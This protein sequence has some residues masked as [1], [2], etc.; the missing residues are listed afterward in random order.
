MKDSKRYGKISE[1]NPA[2]RGIKP[3]I[4][5]AQ[6]N[7][8][9]EWADAMEAAED[10]PESSWGAAIAQFKELYRVEGGAWVK[11][12]GGK[13]ARGE[14]QG[15]DGPRQGDGGAETCI[16]PKCKHEIKHKR[17]TPCSEVECPECGAAMAGKE[18]ETDDKA[19]N[20]ADYLE[21]TIHREF[22][23]TA[24]DLFGRG[25]INRDERIAI[26][27]L[28]GDALDVFRHGLEGQLSELQTRDT[29]GGSAIELEEPKPLKVEI[30]DSS[31]DEDEDEKAGRRVRSDKVSILKSLQEKLVTFIDEFKTVIGW[32]EYEDA[33]DTLPELKGACGFKTFERNGQTWLLT[34]TTNAFRDRED[35][36]FTTKS[37]EDYVSRHTGDDEKGRFQFWHIPGTDFGTIHW[38]GVIGRFLYEAGTFDDTLTGQAF[39][40]FLTGHINGHP[41]FAPDGWGVSHEYKFFREDRKDGIYEWFDKEKTTVLPIGAASNPYT[42]ME[43]SEMLSKQQKEALEGIVGAE[44]AA[45]MIQEGKAD[46]EK[47]EKETDFKSS[48][49]AEVPESEAEGT[50]KETDENVKSIVDAVIAELNAEALDA[51]FKALGE[52]IQALDIGITALTERVEVIEKAPAVEQKE[53]AEPRWSWTA[54]RPSQSEHNT[55]VTGLKTTGGRTIPNAIANIAEQVVS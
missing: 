37:I 43:V 45:D 39:K 2:L 31:D 8:I 18:T 46:T 32:A 49:E 6:A 38:Q 21:S 55:D 28:I 15:T 1:A 16:C 11:R 27:S 42:K 5:L 20:V 54:Q 14:G 33:E 3:L 53:I 36:I 7:L 23:V 51:G 19:Q 52:A 35:E 41:E 10:G 4:T 22:T 48:D 40:G 9:A 47:L 30:V 50:E 17:G 26:S 44:S 29:W 24:D 12:E 25:A 34:R 13:K